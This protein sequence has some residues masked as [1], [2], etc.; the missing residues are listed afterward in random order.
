MK[1]LILF[2]GFP[3]LFACQ[4]GLDHQEKGSPRG[5]FEHPE[6]IRIVPAETKEFTL[7]ALDKSEPKITRAVLL[8]GKERYE[9]YCAVCHGFS[10][11]GDGLATTRGFP[12]PKAFYPDGS[13]QKTIYEVIRH[14]KGEMQGFSNRVPP[15]DSWAMAEYVL[16]L[17]RRK[18]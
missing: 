11:N 2:L 3:I 8:R 16:A 14:G 15:N 6:D 4:P 17:K 5:F 12:S 13:D 1:R 18:K 10:G 7:T 9:I